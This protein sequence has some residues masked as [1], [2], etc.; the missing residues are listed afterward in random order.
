MNIH[1]TKIIFI[2]CATLFLISC[3]DN[4]KH[5]V[6][7]GRINEADSLTLY[8]ERREHTDVTILDSVLLTKEGDFSFRQEALDYAEFY[9][10]R[11]DNQSINFSV[12]ST[13][14][15]TFAANKPTFATTYKVEGSPSSARIQQVIMEVA[16]LRSAIHKLQKDHETGKIADQQFVEQINTVIDNY[17]SKAADMI[18]DE[19]KSTAAYFILFQKIDDMLIFDPS[20][21]KDINLFRAVATVWDT[22]FPKSPRTAQLKDYTLSAIAAQKAFAQQQQTFE[23]LA[24]DGETSSVDFYTIALPDINNKTISTKSLR[25]K[26]VLLDFT[27]YQ[28]EYSAAHNIRLNQV[29][30]KYKGRVEIYQVSFDNDVH[31]WKNSAVN[32][33]WIC[34]RD[35]ESLN[36]ALLGKFNIGGFPTTYLLD[37]KGEI[38]KRLPVNVNF[39]TE[40]AKVL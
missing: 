13:E 12:D 22:Y 28:S 11:L 2:A 20:D 37:A 38:V 19:Y 26:I 9:R 29:Y 5:F 10:L 16:K 27:A 35:G 15:I 32:L 39:D 40:I 7:E 36:S 4:Q 24:G 25:G 8:L 1:L 34:V 3:G 31:A 21:K 6:V 30:N 14:T 23:K 18:V 33:P 17:K